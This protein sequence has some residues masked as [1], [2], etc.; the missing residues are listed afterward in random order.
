MVALALGRQTTAGAKGVRAL[1][2]AVEKNATEGQPRSVG[3]FGT[4]THDLLW[5]VVPAEGGARPF[6][7]LI[8][9][10]RNHN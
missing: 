7:L 9:H 8:R 6:S 3:I 4:G 10:I 2:R 1:G 5:M